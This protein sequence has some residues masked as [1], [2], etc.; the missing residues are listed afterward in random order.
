[1]DE[2]R[3]LVVGVDFSRF[4]VSALA[5][6]ARLARL[7]QAK[8][9]AV[10]VVDPDVLEDVQR[11][12]GIPAV[13]VRADF[14]REAR[15]R[16]QT[17]VGELGIDPGSLE[18]HIPVGNPLQEILGEVHRTRADLLVLGEKG[19]W[20]HSPGPGSLATHCVRKADARVLLVREP[21]RG[22]FRRVV[23]CVDGSPTSA[24]ALAEA[25]RMAQG[26]GAHLDAIHVFSPPWRRLHY[27]APTLEATPD[28]QAQY[29]EGLEGFLHGC[30]A[31]FA[32]QFEALRARTHLVESV[33]PWVG[34]VGF[35]R[36][37]EAD[38]AVLGTRG[39]TGWKHLLMGTTA[40]RVIR[41]SPCSILAVKPE[42]F[43]FDA[44]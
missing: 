42:G 12:L 6:A 21:H 24:L 13:Q 43:R 32:A 10:H 8:L 20:E 35:L 34:I 4:S 44:R 39:R 33:R 5:Q 27:R 15:E 17:H 37:T 3:S 18:L 14:V 30:T 28:Q 11:A 36:D 19:D 40:E 26:D 7:A 22:P 31:P 16:L 23:A 41:E 9:H 29:R 38:L 2:A 25:V 1:M